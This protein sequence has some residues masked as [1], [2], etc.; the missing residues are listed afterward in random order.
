MSITKEELD[1]YIAAYQQGNSL[2]PDE[3]WKPIIYRNIRH[4]TYEISNFGNIRRIDDRKYMSKNVR[5]N[6]YEYVRLCLIQSNKSKIFTVHRLVAWHFCKG[7]SK[8]NNVVNHL[9]GNKLNNYYK[10]LEWC[11]QQKNAQHAIDTGLHEIKIGEDNNRSVMTNETVE[12]ICKK[13]IEYNGSITPILNELK[14]QNIYCSFSIID[15]IKQKETWSHISDKY[16]TKNQFKDQKEKEIRLICKTIVKYNGDRN[17]IL[18]ELVSIVPYI[19]SDLISRIITKESYKS[20]S[21]EY[22]TKD[23]YIRKNAFSEKEAH[24]I[25]QSLVDAKGDCNIVFEILKDKIPTLTL[26]KI[27]DIKNKGSYYQISNLYFKRG[28]L[29]MDLKLPV[30]L[31]DLIRTLYIY[32]TP[33]IIFSGL[34]HDKYP[35][36]TPNIVK[37][38]CWGHHEH[39]CYYESNVFDLNEYYKKKHAGEH[40]SIPKVIIDQLI[41]SY[42]LGNSDIDDSLY[43][44]LLEEYLKE[45]GEENRPFSRQKQSSAINASVG[46]LPKT[47]GVIEPMREGQLTYREWKEKKGIPDDA[48]IVVQPKL[49]GGSVACDVSGDKFIYA[50]R[51]DYDNGESEDVTEVFVHHDDVMKKA[52]EK[53][54]KFKCMKFESIMPRDIFDRVFDRKYTRP[55]D[56]MAAVL[57]ARRG[58]LA[59]D[60]VHLM[61]LRILTDQGQKVY[62]GALDGECVELD[63]NNYEGIQCFIDNLLDHGAMVES[64]AGFKYECDGVVI[65][66]VSRATGLIQDEVA[67]KIL[68]M[69]KE[70]KLLNIEYQ[71]GTSCRVTPV[72][73]LEPVKFG[74]VTVSRVTLSNLN[75]VSEMNLRYNDTV[76]IMYNIVPYFMDSKHDGDIII[77]MIEKCPV[78]GH[79][80][81]TRFLKVI[82]CTNPNCNARKL[83]NII[84]YCKNMKMMG[85]AENTINALWDNGLIRDIRDLYKLTKEAI[86]NIDGF[87]EKSAMNIINSIKKASENIPIERWLGSLPITGVSNK[88]WKNIMRSSYG[89]HNRG[90]NIFLDQ[91]KNACNPEEILSHLQLPYGVGNVTISKIAEGF[92]LYWDIIRDTIVNGF[93]SFENKSEGENSNGI[94]VALSGTRDPELIKFLESKGYEVIDYNNSCS[95]LIIPDET[96]SSSKVIKAKEKGKTIVR[97]IQL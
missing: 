55:R 87:K 16:F 41:K 34:N 28:E 90:L 5:G 70:T 89:T 17:L 21:D 88:T 50:T 71:M 69:V 24:L 97:E 19:S 26:D 84:R 51:G 72:A 92:R 33:A 2:I 8:T 66:V 4:N 37:L 7:Y 67:I 15:S 81:D 73:I 60:Y 93:V 61:P 57:H 77:P 42:S 86:C 40:I 68:N 47:Y 48:L 22:F 3:E 75:R 83:G 65:S 56:A 27:K 12:F 45:H 74:D 10:N 58:D 95:I 23:Q 59:K 79:P 32:Y 96:F 1:K 39:K 44:K 29:K 85:V 14:L 38:I 62:M 80:F 76:R 31:L 52:I 53:L 54:G 64:D 91:I 9:D 46:T 82:E 78:C 36:V 43:D 94:K 20:I 6:G 18:K 63:A 13:L 30:Y 25:C 35:T 11:T 49:D